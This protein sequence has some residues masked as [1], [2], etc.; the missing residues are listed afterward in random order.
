VAT[1]V[2]WL[3]AD[4]PAAGKQ[5]Y[6]T[7]FGP[8]T[9]Q[10]L[11]AARENAARSSDVR[12]QD[13]L[14]Q[15]VS[16]Y[17]GLP[18]TAEALDR[19]AEWA[20]ERGELG[21]A[22]E[23]WRRLL[24]MF[25]EG[26]TVAPRN[27]V[28]ARL[29][30]AH[31]MLGEVQALQEL[32]RQYKA[33][34]SKVQVAG[35]RV[36]LRDHLERM[37]ALCRQ[38]AGR[39]PRWLK[40]SAIRFAGIGEL[41]GV[42]RYV[43][44]V[45]RGAYDPRHPVDY[46]PVLGPEGRLYIKG[47]RGVTCLELYSAKTVATS[48]PFDGQL[49][50]R[51]GRRGG[52]HE[53]AEGYYGALSPHG[54]VTTYATGSAG[55]PT[56]TLVCHDRASLQEIW[57]RPRAANERDRHL[58]TGLISAIMGVSGKRIFVGVTSGAGDVSSYLYCLDARHGQ[59]I[60]KRFLC[61]RHRVKKAI[62][63]LAA[64]TVRGPTVYVSTN[65][66]VVAALSAATG[67]VRWLVRYDEQPEE[68]RLD[69]TPGQNR[70]FLQAPLLVGD[71]VVFTPPDTP[72]AVMLMATSGE[73]VWRLTAGE[74][75]GLRY[76]LGVGQRGYFYLGGTQADAISETP[77]S[78]GPGKQLTRQVASS[79]LAYDL[80][81]EKEQ[82]GDWRFDNWRPK[83]TDNGYLHATLAVH[84]SRYSVT[85]YRRRT[86][87]PQDIVAV[88]TIKDK[89]GRMLL[90]PLG[91]NPR[92][93]SAHVTLSFK[94]GDRDVRVRV[95]GRIFGRPT[96]TRDQLL[97]AT[98]DGVLRLDRQHALRVLGLWPKSEMKRYQ[99][100]NLQLFQQVGKPAMLVVAGPS[101]LTIYQA[102]KK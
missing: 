44:H 52:S 81:D 70:W 22:V 68:L 95:F 20:L 43:E 41:S 100:G 7:R 67:Q 94:G 33:E 85:L 64:V 40:P 49:R 60:W 42:V 2:G 101:S 3:L 102:R 72:R 77:V 18:Q 74:N 54:F 88:G 37:L 5:I 78:R 98:Q 1:Y 55:A 21:E 89:T 99:A 56:S 26:T 13:P 25:P 76:L 16:L 17:R 47:Y 15:I 50:K 93:R 9:D 84:D 45:G 36:S 86:R 35:Q 69:G 46:F 87:R 30:L 51:F 34:P 75:S 38:Q 71:R 90:Q 23:H 28:V 91:G 61:S 27:Q 8:K 4:L 82:L 65:Q 63:P 57:R 92:K 62:L 59:V 83:D 19:L 24:R 12:A 97:V 73:L 80:G 10:L 66:G 14:L 96:L 48:P 11:A 6:R 39:Q 58:R 32:L 79:A 29:A 31:S 53:L